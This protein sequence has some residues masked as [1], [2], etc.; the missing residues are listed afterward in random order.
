M[1][2]LK[3]PDELPALVQRYFVNYLANQRNLSHH[4]RSG[5]RD[6]FRLFLAFL[7]KRHRCS[8]DQLT[9]KAIDPTGILAFLD[10]LETTRGNTP[11]TRNLRLA[12]IRTFARFVVGESSGVEFVAMA[13]RI[14]AIP[15]KKSPARVLGF[16][17][18]QEIDA[19]IAAVDPTTPS[20][21][22]D[23]ILFLLLYNT[24]ARI[25]E[26]LQ[27]RSKDIA[28]RTVHLHGKGRKERTVP[29]WATTEKLL[30]QRCKAEN[31]EPEGLVFTNRNGEQLSRDGVAFRLALAVNKAADRCPSLKGR[32]ITCHTFR[33]S[34]A[35]ALLQAGVALEAMP[36]RQFCLDRKSL[37]FRPPVLVGVFCDPRPTAHGLAQS[38]RA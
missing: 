22:R 26:G 21:K 24:G 5:Y 36:L 23:R 35:M 30:R 27:L 37:V 12:A 28:G 19:V 1:R 15:K 25:S 18:R 11:R 29:I 33:H 31:I 2:K 6:A 17:T 38:S 14:L 20:G 10:Y 7:A 32:R 3:Q 16:M 8:I 34:C 13:H 9:L 4:T